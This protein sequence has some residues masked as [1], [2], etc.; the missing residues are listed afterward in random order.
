MRFGYDAAVD[1]ATARW[2]L[3]AHGIVAAAAVAATTHWCVWLWP[4]VRGRYT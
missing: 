2:L 1:V 3:I 4:F